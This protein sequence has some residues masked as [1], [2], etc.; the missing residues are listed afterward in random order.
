MIVIGVGYGALLARYF[1][2]KHGLKLIMIDPIIGTDGSEFDKLYIDKDK[3]AMP[4]LVL[5]THHSAFNDAIYGVFGLDR[6]VSYTESTE[7]LMRHIS[8]FIN[9]FVWVCGSINEDD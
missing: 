6:M 1:A 7:S 8:E 4:L 3:G 5:L 2:N 9:H